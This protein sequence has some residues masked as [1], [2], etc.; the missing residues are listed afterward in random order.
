MSRERR[1]QSV[2]SLPFHARTDA[3]RAPARSDMAALTL[4]PRWTVPKAI[5]QRPHTTHV[6]RVMHPH[7]ELSPRKI[8]DWVTDRAPFPVRQQHNRVVIGQQ[9]VVR[10]EVSMDENTMSV[11]LAEEG[12]FDRLQLA[13][14]ATEREHDGV[15]VPELDQN[16]AVA[17]RDPSEHQRTRCRLHDFS[18]RQSSGESGEGKNLTIVTLTRRPHR[19]NASRPGSPEPPHHW[20][21]CAEGVHRPVSPSTSS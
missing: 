10:P 3:S 6:I 17:P 5:E 20:Y 19:D 8:G 14:H 9:H 12:R 2:A 18:D 11:V 16:L 21:T 13:E 15:A 1:S 7:D 4:G